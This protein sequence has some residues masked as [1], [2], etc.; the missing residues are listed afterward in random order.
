MSRSFKRA[1][2]DRAVNEGLAKPVSSLQKHFFN[3]DHFKSLCWFVTILLSCLTRNQICTPALG[4]QSP[5]YSTARETPV[6]TF[7]LGYT[8][9]PVTFYPALF[10]GPC[11][12]LKGL[13]ATIPGNSDGAP[14][15]TS[16]PLFLGEEI[17]AQRDSHPHSMTH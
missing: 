12:V 4:E 9:A 13:T 17:E 3:A 5:D 16:Q 1:S 2:Q 6:S 11:A 7:H 8:P 10:S 14:L 15:S